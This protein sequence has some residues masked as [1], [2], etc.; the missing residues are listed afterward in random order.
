[1]NKALILEIKGN[2]LD[3]GPGIRTVVFFKGCP[4]NCVWCHNPESKQS[5]VELSWDSR[6]CIGCD[7]CITVCPHNAIS[8]KNPY[9]VNRKQCTLCFDCVNVCPSGALTKVGTYMSVE[10][11]MKSVQK[12]KPFF[13]TSGGGVTLSGGEPTINMQFFIQ[14]VQKL[15]EENIHIVVETCGL[16][17]FNQFMKALP[18][19]D[20]IYF[21]IKL[22]HEAEHKKFCGVSN[23]TI[24]KNFLQLAKMRSIYPFELLPRVP[25]IP[26]ITATNHN[27]QAIASFLKDAKFTHVA[28][29][30]YNPL[31]QQKCANI[32]IDNSLVHKE[33]STWM[34]ANEIERCQSVFIRKGIEAL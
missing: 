11:I 21:D 18:Y 31:W 26:S 27:L 28:L 34:S 3:D 19:I 30:R 6:E 7:S 33:F 2:S 20:A 12:D 10:D 23:T 24:I 8:R 25:L 13:D 29:L 4:L 15:K 5:T 17:V 1:M 9:F 16:F 32:G 14:I 22:F